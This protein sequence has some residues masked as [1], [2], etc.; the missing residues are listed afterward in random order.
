MS[1]SALAEG[2]RNLRG[3][4]IVQ[5]LHAASD[6]QLLHAFLRRRDENAFAVLVRR[7]GPMVW[8]V[9][10]RVLG[11][12]Q[13]AE[14]AFQATF[15]VLA[16]SAAT[17][18][19]RTSLSSWL[20][21]TAYRVAMKTKRS[22]ARR[23]KHE[24]RA[25]S[26]MSDD[27]TQELSWRELRTQLDEEVARLSEIYRAVFVLCCLQNQSVAETALQLGL[28]VGTVASRLAEAR[29]RLAQR[30][31]RRGVQLTAVLALS[32]LAGSSASA[33]SPALI[34][35]TIKAAL[36]APTSEGCAVL[37]SARVVELVKHAAAAAL[38]SKTRTVTVL[39]LAVT[40]LAGAG[41]W[42]SR[43]LA[44]SQIVGLQGEAVQS[45]D[46]SSTQSSTAK[47][48]QAPRREKNEFFPVSGQVLDPDGNPFPS[49]KL[50][51]SLVSAMSFIARDLRECRETS[52]ADGRFRF[53]IP[54]TDL[55]KLEPDTPWDQVTV[56]AVAAGYGP[57]WS[58][59]TP[60]R[61]AIGLNLRLVKDDVPINARILDLE[62]R[63]IRGV[64]VR[65]QAIEDA[66]DGRLDFDSLPVLQKA[67]KTDAQGR[68]RLMGFGRDRNV[69]LSL[70]GQTIA[71]RERDLY[72]ITRD[73]KPYH[74]PLNK[75]APEL[76]KISYYGATADIIAA[77]TKPIVGTV[78]DK[79]TGKPLSGVT[80]QSYFRA[81]NGR[82]VQD[83][84]RTKSDREGKYRL[85]GMPKGKGNEIIA[86][87]PAGQPYFLSRKEVS[88]TL[89]LDDVRV[90]F[91]LKRGVWLRGRVT[92]NVTG[93]PVRA[94]IQYGTFLDNAH[95]RDAPGYSGSVTAVTG[96]DGSFDVLGL[97]GRGLLAVKADEDRFL[98]SIGLDQIPAADKV[99]TN[100]EHLR[101][102][103]LFVSAEYHAFVL[104]NP[105][106]DD[107]AA[108]YQVRLDSGKTIHG[109]IQDQDGKPLDGVKVMDLK[110]M[111]SLPQPLSGSRFTATALDPRNPRQLF[112]YHGDKQLGAAV[113]VRGDEEKPLT[114]RLQPG[115]SVTGRILDSEGHPLSDWSIYGQS[116]SA[117][118]SITNGRWWNLYVSGRT[119]KQGQFRIGLIP[120]VAYNIMIGGQNYSLTLKPGEKKDLGDTKL[121]TGRAENGASSHR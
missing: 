8:H 46:A 10:R 96:A 109:T 17:L 110:M 67:T 94:R 2:L 73:A 85:E 60:N 71:A 37:T 36:V 49:A 77:P 58:S 30:L 57:A 21:G 12:E 88:D 55:D 86:I 78:R 98:P 95:L 26:R 99:V 11:H 101:T 41:V 45:A 4:L 59:L 113:L 7:Y 54:R 3:K 74:V 82:L 56:V 119:D 64:R 114:I 47:N 52:A 104:V 72:V 121:D 33:L 83:Y 24:R 81:G 97:P 25:P 117:Y 19:N 5:H 66:Q 105:T 90:D 22:A 20:H 16:Q 50:Y 9:C 65:A 15:L 89:G 116:Q 79:D 120:G 40:T 51:Y 108:T 115:G 103:P 29:K 35:A 14:D 112:F 80:I 61:P 102:E 1:S 63:P 76:G 111:W 118:M 32:T 69:E 39:L 92:D 84:L 75:R 42:A 27:P 87:A 13:D 93:K 43:T 106:E 53:Q 70:R 28:K 6:E 107:K 91:A 18:R 68:F 48:T 34:A 23:H 31:A 100:F 62:G 44:V 38:R